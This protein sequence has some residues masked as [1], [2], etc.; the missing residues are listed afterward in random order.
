[1]C[2]RGQLRQT[3]R[4][5]A[6]GRPPG[7]L[8]AAL[9]PYLTLRDQ[10]DRLCAR[11]VGD[12][13]AALNCRAGCAGCCTLRGVLPVE[14]AGLFL[15]WRAL[16]AAARSR[17][18]RQLAGPAADDA[19]PLL[20]ED[21]CPLYDARP[22]ICR[23]HGLPLLVEEAAG[24]RV[25]CCPMNFTGHSSLPGTAVIDLERLNTALVT[26]NRQFVAR[27]LANLELP[28]RIPLR[29]LLAIPWPGTGNNRR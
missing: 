20:A 6:G 12:Y 17:L 7:L 21:L 14:A 2:R 19:C 16:P 29:D 9:T 11:I 10:V 5:T 4:V 15:A 22:I 26:L 28:D 27:L 25:D 1:M 18:R 13:G 8:V 23:T 3:G 24:R